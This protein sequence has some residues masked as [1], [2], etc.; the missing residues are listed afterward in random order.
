[1]KT[2]KILFHRHTI[3]LLVILT[4]FM[5]FIE[6]CRKNK[7]NPESCIKI[8]IGEVMDL[9][10]PTGKILTRIINTDIS[11]NEVIAKDF[12]TSGSGY[13]IHKL[14]DDT[15]DCALVNDIPA[16][17]AFQ[18]EGHYSDFK[19]HNSL[20]SLCSFFSDSVIFIVNTK[21]GIE[22]FADIKGKKIAIAEEGTAAIGDLSKFMFKFYNI[23]PNDF[24]RLPYNLEK[25]VEELEKGNLD[26]FLYFTALPNPYLIGLS[27]S[28]KIKY[29]FVQLNADLMK[30]LKKKYPSLG[31]VTIPADGEYADTGNESEITTLG[32]RVLLLATT[33]MSNDIA[34]Y[35]TN[36]ICTYFPI[37]EK[38]HPAYQGIT[39]ESMAKDLTLPVH[40]G[41]LKYYKEAGLAKYIPKDLLPDSQ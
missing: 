12:T 4:G 2:I 19:N 13:N 5:L 8:G 6:G 7:D 34:Y 26:G 37:Y 25:S 32:S 14:L 18:G 28:D 21:S 9:F 1:M 29:K 11:R 41:A 35:L 22:S 27:H 36:E 39:P 17:M 33:N 40:P 3:I 31:Y 30:F 10:N 38:V 20:R 16:V 23:K 24:T 15:F